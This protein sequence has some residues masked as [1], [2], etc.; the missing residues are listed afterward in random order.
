MASRGRGRR[1]RPRGTGPPPP[2][3]NPKAFMETMGATVATIVQAC[4]AGG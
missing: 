4:V 2:V 1:G 3:F